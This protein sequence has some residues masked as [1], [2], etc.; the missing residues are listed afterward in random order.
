MKL[1]IHRGTHEIGGSCLELSSNSG[2]TRAIIDIGLPLVNADGSPFDWDFRRKFSIDQLLSENTLPPIKGLYQDVQP[3]VNAVLLSHAHLDHYGLLRFVHPETPLYMSKG[4]KSLAEVS[5][6]FLNADVILDGVKTFTMWQPFQVGEF[7]ITPYL[8]DHSAPDAA[9]FLVEGD[10]QRL[11]YTGD[12]RGHGRKRVLLERLGT[13]PPPNIGYLVMEG[14]MFGRSEGLFADE[15]AVEQA[16]YQHIHN[17]SGP[18]YIFASSQNLDRLVSIFRATKRSGKI[19]VIDLYTAFVLDKLGSL[20]PNIPQFDWEGIRVLFSYYHAGK[21]AEQDKR[22]LYKYRKAKIDFEKLKQNPQNKV[23][24]T[25]DS[26]YFRILCSKL[27]SN[28]KASAIYSMW[29]GY[30]ERSDLGQF[31]EASEVPIKE[32]HTSGHAYVNQLKELADALRPSFIIPMHTFYPEKYADLFSNV[33]QLK[34]GEMIDFDG[35]VKGERQEPVRRRALSEDFLRKFKEGIYHPLVQRIRQDKDLDMEFRGTYINVYYQGHNILNL[36]RN[37]S[38]TIDNKFQRDIEEQIPKVFKTSENLDTYLKLLP[39]IKDNVAYL[40]QET[41]VRSSR[42][43]EL[44]FE[45]LLI[46]ANNLESRNNSEYIIL[47]RQYV[48]N[49]GVDRWD[50]VALRWSIEK[51]GRPYQEGYLSVIEVKYAQN[52]DIQNIKNQVE[53][54]ARYLKANLPNICDDMKNIL[55][56]KLDLNLLAKTD[57]QIKRLRKLPIVPDILETEVIIYL[58]DYNNNNSLLERAKVVGKPDFKGRVRVAFGGLALWQS[59]SE[60]W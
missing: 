12:F 56:Q 54:Y 51:R 36:K 28:T 20:S 48:V 2:Y 43:R 11:F 13:N 42:S 58:I 32:I 24:L 39:K 53:R 19:F 21:L 18:T 55:D 35:K 23:L 27:C 26:R 57:G 52:P 40:P 6:I 10:G 60:P 45:Q 33:I 15:D 38:V 50:L 1:T 4:T 44:E 14:S 34:D 30:L 47:D 31:L 7:T 3:S 8:V 16:I 17:R 22:L 59:S 49:R 5:N 29:H 37:G 46:R 25:K 9:A 41:G